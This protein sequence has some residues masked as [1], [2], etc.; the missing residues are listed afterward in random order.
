[1]QAHGVCCRKKLTAG[2]WGCAQ[3]YFGTLDPEVVAKFALQ[4]FRAEWQSNGSRDARIYSLYS[5]ACASF[6]WEN[7]LSPL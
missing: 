5:Q 7:K 4:K 3:A 2:G 6:C 1:M